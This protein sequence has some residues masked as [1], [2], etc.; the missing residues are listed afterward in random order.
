MLLPLLHTQDKLNL[1]M[2]YQIPQ[3]VH[4][5]PNDVLDLRPDV[6]IDN[7]LVRPQ[8]IIDEKNVW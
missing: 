1:T 7:D 4:A 6:E 5:I 2:N 3:S 8:S